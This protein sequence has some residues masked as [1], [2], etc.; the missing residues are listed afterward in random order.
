MN[1]N[2]LQEETAKLI[3]VQDVEGIPEVIDYGNN[4]DQRYFLATQTLGPSFSQIMKI[5]GQFSLKNVLLIGIQLIKL[6]QKMHDKKYI[7]SNILPCN[8]CMGCELEDKLIYLKDLTFVQSKESN[9]KVLKFPIKEFN[10]ISP[11]LN[12]EKGTN[13]IDELYSLAYLLIYLIHGTLP[14]QQ[15][16]QLISE[17]Q[18]Y[19]LQKYKLKVTFDQSFL[20][21]QSSVFGEWFKYLSTLKQSQHPNYNYL[22]NILISKIYENGWKPNDQIEYR[23]EQ[24]IH[25]SKSIVSIKSRSR[26]TS[27]TKTPNQR[28]IETLSPI[29]EV[30]KEFELAQSVQK[31]NEELFIF[32]KFQNIKKLIEDQQQ[33][34]NNLSFTSIGQNECEMWKKLETLENLSRPI[35]LMNK[36]EKM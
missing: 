36:F 29:L 22:K 34:E 26:G 24:V 5:N 6:I 20:E 7:L 12:I 16:D 11:V 4:N 35:Y 1:S 31:Q 9:I 23:N 10:F 33:T 14:W 25:S 32:Q 17:K 2:V 13:Q 28:M 27:I 3:Q 19:E 21:Q 18:F 30:D 15:I 8:F